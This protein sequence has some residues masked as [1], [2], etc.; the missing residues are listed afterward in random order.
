MFQTIHLANRRPI[1]FKESLRTDNA[2]D[3]IS[4]ITPEMLLKG[5]ELASLNIIPHLQSAPEKIQKDVVVNKTPSDHIRKS[6]EKLRIARNR[7]S[8]IYRDEFQAQ[9]I[10]QATD[11]K[12]RYQPV[13][14][15]KPEVG[16]VVLIK[17]INL[18]RM[19]YPMGIVKEIQTNINDEV[20]GVTILKGKTREKIKRHVSS[21]IPLLGKNEV[22]K[23]A[24][25]N[26]LEE[27]NL[28][29]EE[30]VSM[31]EIKPNRKAAIVGQAR[32]QDLAKKD[33]I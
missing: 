17:E 20:T 11:K 9:M 7:L 2:D 25:E 8:T 3:I 27:S 23:G 1:A 32:T 24:K 21:I 18:K 13:T 29:D 31:K 19:D 12:N 16:D 28:K 15:K 14:H 10:V 22:S 4:P 6:F 30:K 33:L 5:Y 26:N